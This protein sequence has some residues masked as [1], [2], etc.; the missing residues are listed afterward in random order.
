MKRFLNRDFKVAKILHNK[1]EF[2]II[3]KLNQCVKNVYNDC[4]VIE[5]L[6]DANDL[7]KAVIVD[8][9]KSTV[10]IEGFNG[11]R[12]VGSTRPAKSAKLKPLEGVLVL[13]VSLVPII[14]CNCSANP[15][16]VSKSSSATV[17]MAELMAAKSIC[18]YICCTI[19]ISIL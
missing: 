8:G 4:G 1:T 6:A 7:R 16:S 3:N 2:K 17:S 12:P 15:G 11:V 5:L 9:V 13:L 18:A 19:R 14:D 10:V